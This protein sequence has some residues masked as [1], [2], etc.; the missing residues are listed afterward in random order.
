MKFTNFNITFYNFISSTKLKYS[1]RSTKLSKKL[2][3]RT[4]TEINQ[5]DIHKTK[6][7]FIVIDRDNSYTANPFLLQL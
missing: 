3:S 6:F 2:L 4:L 5:P 1:S 7:G